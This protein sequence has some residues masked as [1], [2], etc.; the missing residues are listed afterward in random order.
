MHHAGRQPKQTTKRQALRR[1]QQRAAL[2][3]LNGQLTPHDGPLFST[4]ESLPTLGASTDGIPGQSEPSTGL[5]CMPRLLLAEQ[6]GFPGRLAFEGGTPSE[7]ISASLLQPG[8]QGKLPA[9]N[10]ALVLKR[11]AMVLIPQLLGMLL[12]QQLELW[13]YGVHVCS[14]WKHLVDK[15]SLM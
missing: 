1:L 10:C 3:S 5:Q 7:T 11:L 2:Q 4:P 8:Q 12:V 9:T 14:W 15:P 13:K 6:P